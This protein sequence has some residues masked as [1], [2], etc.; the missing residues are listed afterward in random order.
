M[1]GIS[2]LNFNDEYFPNKIQ[3][4]ED[5][6]IITWL[7][8]HLYLVQT[9]PRP[10]SYSVFDGRESFQEKKVMR[11][12]ELGEMVW[13]AILDKDINNFGHLINAVHESQ[14][15]MIPGYESEQVK[16][17]IQKAQARYLG[18][19]LMGA[20]GFGYVMVVS[21]EPVENG[22]SVEITLP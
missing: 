15:D 21:S 19:K 12:S 4:V 10:D 5:K 7:S 14:K 16:P 17:I 3:S 8:K 20:G 18:A 9:K 1:P 11:H 6:S 2:K 13:Q 22:I